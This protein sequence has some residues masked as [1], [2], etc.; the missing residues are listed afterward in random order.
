MFEWVQTYLRIFRDLWWYHI[1][2]E[3]GII[4]LVRKQNL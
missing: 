1:D 2:P 3:Q 4:H